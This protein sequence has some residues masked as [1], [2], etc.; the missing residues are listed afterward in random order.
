VESAETAD[1]GAAESGLRGHG[2][3]CWKHTAWRGF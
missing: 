3:F 1:G 2:R